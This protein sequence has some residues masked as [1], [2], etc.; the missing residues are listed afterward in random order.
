MAYAGAMPLIPGSPDIDV[1]TTFLISLDDDGTLVIQ[2]T[3]VGDGF[4]CAEAFVR[5]GDGRAVLLHHYEVPVSDLPWEPG[6]WYGPFTGPT[7]R[8][9]GDSERPMGATTTRIPPTN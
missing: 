2:T 5:L 9:E 7:T 4:P 6:F 8:L 3:M 1:H